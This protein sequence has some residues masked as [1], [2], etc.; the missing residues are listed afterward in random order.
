M[1]KNPINYGILGCGRHARLAHAIPGKDIASLKLKSLCDISSESMTALE[2]AHG[3]NLQ[4]YTHRKEFF[5]SDIEAVLIATPDEHHFN[6]LKEVLAAGKHAFTE[7]P[8]VTKAEELP[9][10]ESLLKQA[11]I[12]NLVVTSCH[13]RR[14]NPPFVWLKE[15]IASLTEKLGEP[16]IFSFDFSYHRPSKQWKHERGLLIDHIN[17]EID[18]V[19]YIFGYES[20][21][22]TKLVN[23]F[24]E[25]RVVGLRKDG[26]QFDFHGTR[27]LNERRYFEFMNVRFEKGTIQIET[28]NQLAE[29]YDHDS[30]VK[31][32][33]IIPVA[34][35]GASSRGTMENFAN[36]ILGTEN[37][38][39][40]HVDLYVNNATGVMLTEKDRWHYDF[41]V[42]A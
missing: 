7:K 18:L 42:A 9:E 38:Y 19:H 8:I 29:L 39:L 37:C 36:A 26:L 30:G 32:N 21:Q 4:K 17:H 10:L 25:Y 3:E 11:A 16:I 35:Y 12:N 22:A 33:M 28:N 20:F 34:D 5:N 27:R 24:D 40:S 2:D 23:R 15:N 31:I 13:L 14:Y 41:G 1:A 6:D